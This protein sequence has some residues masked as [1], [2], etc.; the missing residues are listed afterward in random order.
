MGFC[1][2]VGAALETRRFLSEGK[3]LIG[4]YNA[5]A[6]GVD[7]ETGRCATLI[8]Q[9][10]PLE[11]SRSGR[12]RSWCLATRL[13]DRVAV[14]EFLAFLRGF[15]LAPSVV[16]SICDD[17]AFDSLHEFLSATMPL[18]LYARAQYNRLLTPRPQIA[19]WRLENAAIALYFASIITPHLPAIWAGLHL[20]HCYHV[21]PGPYRCTNV[22]DTRDHVEEGV[23]AA[24]R[25]L[26]DH[27]D[28][29]DEATWDALRSGQAQLREQ[30]ESNLAELAE[31]GI[32][33][34]VIR[35]R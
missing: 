19:R 30:G 32:K 8:L 18:Y 35:I 17:E 24:D 21:G 5:V 34:G 7:D 12:E 13:G 4:E 33:M 14:I 23:H 26:K 1:E 2:G 3:V 20:L 16:A 22:T 28:T 31:R 11:D 15:G 10:M 25:F 9:S 27:G 6:S 29:L